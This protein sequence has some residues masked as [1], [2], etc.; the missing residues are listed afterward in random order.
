MIS[1]NKQYFLNYLAEKLPQPEYLRLQKDEQ[2][3]YSTEHTKRDTDPDY[4]V[5]LT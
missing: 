4:N 3:S 5:H 2:K 1:D